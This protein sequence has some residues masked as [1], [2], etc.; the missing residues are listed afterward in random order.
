MPWLLAIQKEKETKKKQTKGYRKARFHREEKTPDPWGG[1]T[2]KEGWMSCLAKASAI[3]C[4]SASGE[5]ETHTGFKTHSCD[6]AFRKVFGSLFC[7]CGSHSAVDNTECCYLIFPVDA[8]RGQRRRNRTWRQ[9]RK[10]WGLFKPE[11]DENST[12]GVEVD[13][14]ERVSWL[15]IELISLW[16]PDIKSLDCRRWRLI[17]R[18]RT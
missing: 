11:R 2:K 8:S 7:K 4:F 15:I 12:G 18:V 10:L 5:H 1:K 17:W 16:H 13:W 14:S 3:S 9:Y 6:V